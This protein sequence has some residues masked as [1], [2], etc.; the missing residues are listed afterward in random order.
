MTT[1]QCFATVNG[2]LTSLGQPAIPIPVSGTE[3]ERLQKLFDSYVEALLKQ[4][5]MYRELPNRTLIPDA[6]VQMLVAEMRSR[7]ML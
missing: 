6:V 5:P 2:I 7:K 1:D 3:D 4:S